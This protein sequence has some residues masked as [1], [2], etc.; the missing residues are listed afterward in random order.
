MINFTK[1]RLQGFKSFVE[2][3][4]LDIGAG[5][6]GIVGPNGCGKSN[7]VEA[8]SW[9]MGE[10]S[11][12]RLRGGE[13]EDVIFAGTSG[14]PA[15]NNAEV[16]V[17][18][19]NTSRKAPAIFNTTDEIEVIRRIERDMGSSYYV[20][21]KAVRARD[22][23]MLFADMAI[24]AH[25]MAIVSQGRIAAVINAK[26]A[27]RRQILEEAAGVS[28]LYVRRHEAELRLRAADANLA[29]LQDIVA[30]LETQLDSLKRQSRQATRYKNVSGDIRA[31][32]TMLALAEWLMA[33]DAEAR[34]KFEF[35]E[36]ERQV[37]DRMATVA[38]LTNTQMTQ[39]EEVPP[40]RE[41]QAETA[42]AWQVQNFE[43]KRLDDEEQRITAQIDEAKS[44]LAQTKADSEHEQQTTEENARVLERMAQEESELATAENTAEEIA[45]LA[46]ERDARE[47]DVAR[48]QSIYQAA[49]EQAATIRASRNTL[50]NQLSQDDNRLQ[51]LQN[52]LEN[53]KSQIAQ[54]KEQQGEAYPIEAMTAELATLEQNLISRKEEEQA[55]RAKLEQDQSA[56]DEARN[57]VQVAREKLSKIQAEANALESVLQADTQQ[58][59]RPV[60]ED[61]KADEGFEAALSKA[62]GDTLMASTQTDAPMTWS[63]KA[64]SVSAPSFP[65][66]VQ[67]LLPHIRA[68]KELHLALSFIGYVENDQDG[69]AAATQLQAGQ[70]IV[71]RDGAYWRWDGLYIRAKAVDRTAVRLKN[72][73]RLEELQGLLPAAQAENDEAQAKLQQVQ[74]EIATTRQSVQSSEQAARVADKDLNNKRV[75]L[76]RT[77]ERKSAN[78]SELLKLEEALILQQDDAIRLEGA[79]STHKTSLEAFD[80]SAIERQNSD[81]EKFREDLQ[82]AQNALRD[83]STAFEIY[84]QN[85]NRREARLRAIA[86]ERVN[87]QNRA[88]RAQERLRQ[89]KERSEQMQ[90]RLD[91][92]KNRPGEI[93]TARQALLDTLSQLEGLKNIAA[94]KLAAAERELDET[95]KG[96]KIAE[97]SLME[98]RE[99]R[100]HA[101]AMIEAAAGSLEVL[102]QSVQ[103]QF[104]MTPEQLWEQSD[105]TKEKVMAEPIDKMRGKRD[106]L[107]RER[108]NM[109]AV[110]LR[111]DIESQEVD[112][113]LAK[114][115]QES[116]DLTQ[117]IEELRSG[118]QKLNKEARERLM[119]AFATVNAHFQ[120]L[121]TRLFGGGSAHLAFIES[122]DPLNAALE[123]YAQPPGKSLQ[124]LSLLSGGEKTLASTALIFAMFLTNPAPICVLDEIDAPLDD[125]N[126]DRVCNLLSEISEQSKTRFLMITHHRL[127]MAKMDRLYGVTMA[128]RGVSQLVSV[129]L[130]GKLDFLEA[131]E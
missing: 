53:L 46:A 107:I 16:S 77:V 119:E 131:A 100:A 34:A 56:Q 104:S 30:N 129:D 70:S 47:E 40:L 88:I 121:F 116:A 123:I 97:A 122:E 35:E 125:A 63:D 36:A 90:A 39:A 109:G 45:R 96:L 37:G 117:A 93:L 15:R 58:G 71:S 32:E 127:S 42:A 3:T 29:R 124:S 55:A 9:V 4:E 102:G 76:Q 89:L 92:L 99:R 67:P 44:T 43:M 38:Q 106:R 74:A 13:M 33:Q 20:N 95:N 103:D 50:L 69:E 118:I 83:A 51:S 10:N 130:Q 12:K 62:L 86:D 73:N 52:R 48:A 21:G 11:A 111:A 113:Q 28:G 41:K 1:L 7:L 23:Q 114:L 108:D 68:P 22:V 57:A 82:T 59:F 54:K 120:V 75:E 8:L 91:E 19:D 128:E 27:E 31:T 14:R 110:N 65:A 126:V 6:T 60:L 49:L 79:V 85:T 26:P 81:V 5:M 112:E 115:I 61:V 87:L 24:G 84:Q 80:E 66:N 64:A 2:R 18:L 72:K 94:D 17:V 25:S 78:E 101:Q 98:V 105:L